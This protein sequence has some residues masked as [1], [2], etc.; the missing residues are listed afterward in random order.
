MIESAWSLFRTG[1]PIMWP[2]LIASVLSV[3]VA[4]ER[5]PEAGEP[6]AVVAVAV[7]RARRGEEKGRRSQVVNLASRKPRLPRRYAGR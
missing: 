7:R 2:I 3:A 5:V 6:K 4:I 1:G